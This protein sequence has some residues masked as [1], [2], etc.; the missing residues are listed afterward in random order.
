MAQICVLYMKTTGLLYQIPAQAISYHTK[1][2]TE[3]EE[4]KKEIT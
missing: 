1:E 4:D 3:T 2:W